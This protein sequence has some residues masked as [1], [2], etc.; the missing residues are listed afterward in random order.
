MPSRL[1]G[2]L[3]IASAQAEDCLTTFAGKVGLH[4]DVGPYAPLKACNKVVPGDAALNGDDAETV[5]NSA[6]KITGTKYRACT[7]ARPRP[8]LALIVLIVPLCCICC[9]CFCCLLPKSKYPGH[10]KEFR[11]YHMSHS[12]PYVVPGYMPAERR[13][14]L[15]QQYK[16]GRIEAPTL[17]GG[18]KDSGTPRMS[19]EKTDVGKV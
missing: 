14:Q 12:N 7:C 15:K 18:Q 1:L 19:D 6:Y 8:Y 3:L 11:Q 9:V 4:K 5:C 2:A 10:E 17:A 16:S 13:K